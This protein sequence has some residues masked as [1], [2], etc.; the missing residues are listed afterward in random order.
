MDSDV[1]ARI[2]QKY[3]YKAN[4]QALTIKDK[5]QKLTNYD[6]LII[7]GGV[8]GLSLARELH[9]LGAGPIAVVERGKVGR[10]ASFAAAGMLAP[11]AENEIIDD[12]YGLCDGSRSMFPI[13]ADELHLETEI[14]IE[15]DRTGTLYAAFTEADSHHLDLRFSR[16]IA[17]GIPVTRLSAK[18]TLSM[19]PRLSAS[20]RESLYFPNDWQVENRKLLAALE[21]YAR[22]NGI[23]I[24]D[25]TSVDELVVEGTR[26]IGVAAG[27]RKLF[28]Q[29]TVLATG[30]WTSLI[31]MGNVRLPLTVRPI[32]GQMV[33][34]GPLERILR[35]VIYSPRGYLVPRADGR[36]LAGATVEDV[37]FD[38]SVTVEAANELKLNACE[39]APD[40][41][42]IDV[43]ENWAG[44]RPFAA[45]GSPII[46]PMPG[47]DCLFVAT[48]HYRNGILLA[49][50]TAKIIADRII[51]K[52]DSPYFKLFG[53]ER[54]LN[55]LNANA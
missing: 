3:N 31:K 44:L 50:M 45:D 46:G 25:E 52:T 40:L 55:K 27:E 23:E 21:K 37:G 30:A 18:V 7:G 17:A 12:F 16:Q 41:T 2:L 54:F 38:C 29:V 4:L 42:D 15:L 33:S 48:A 28:S 35:H 13:F 36:I 24:I 49:P 43:A 10:E 26:P 1:S 39:I 6:V 22:G 20:V 5:S 34:F 14:D 51:N 9:R 32:R 8:I 47:M 19:E 11:N 53:P